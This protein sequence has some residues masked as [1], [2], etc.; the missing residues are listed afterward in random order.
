MTELYHQRLL[1]LKET[2]W[3]K[4]KY[5]NLALNL[6]DLS[7]MILLHLIR[8]GK[9]DTMFIDALDPTKDFMDVVHPFMTLLCYLWEPRVLNQDLDKDDK[10]LDKDQGLKNVL[11]PLDPKLQL[12]LKELSNIF[13]LDIPYDRKCS[14]YIMRFL[15][16]R[17]VDSE[18]R[19]SIGIFQRK[20]TNLISGMARMTSGSFSETEPII[21]LL[22]SLDK[23]LRLADLEE[24]ARDK[25]KVPK[26][27]N[28]DLD[29]DLDLDNG[30]KDTNVVD[31]DVQE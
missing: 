2:G 15:K 16:N 18:S 23:E 20:L 19:E 4:S 13:G 7:S 10:D 25:S 27:I 14:D 21:T 24:D 5:S 17:Q 8:K 22:K 28:M 30:A 31:N 26:Y 6:E 9:I 12:E 11:A 3:L 1:W 29:L